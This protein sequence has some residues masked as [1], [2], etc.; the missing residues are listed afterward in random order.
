MTQI[1]D[2]PKWCSDKLKAL[3][4]NVTPKDKVEAEKHFSRPTIDKY[5]SGDVTKLQT[6]IDLIKFFDKKVNDRIKSISKMGDN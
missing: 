6:A 3:N 4:N 5:L 1:T 2:I